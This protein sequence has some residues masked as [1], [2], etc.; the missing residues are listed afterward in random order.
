LAA[1]TVA[2]EPASCPGL[3]QHHLSARDTVLAAMLIESG[4]KHLFAEWPDSPQKDDEKAEFFEQIAGLHGSYPGGIPAYISSA[5]GHLAA[6]KSGENPMDGF[7]PKVPEGKNVVFPSKQFSALE[8]R[9][10]NEAGKLCFVLVAGGLGE[11]LGYSGIKVALP[12]ELVT[13]T[14]YLELYAKGILALQEL[15]GEGTKLPL[16][17][18]TSGDTDAPT[19]ALLKENNYFGLDESQVTLIKQEKVA[20][21]FNNDAHIAPDKKSPFKVRCP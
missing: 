14:L 20:A 17:I 11:R 8:A 13:G 5:K 21:L 2:E 7:M 10:A 18:M 6:S 4:Q 19:A 3:E 12:S 1:A 15:A 16:A 9:G